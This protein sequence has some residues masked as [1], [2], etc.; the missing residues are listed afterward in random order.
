MASKSVENAVGHRTAARTT[1]SRREVLAKPDRQ[2][3]KCKTRELCQALYTEWAL[4]HLCHWQECLQ[5]SGLAKAVLNDNKDI[6]RSLVRAEA[7]EWSLVFSIV[8][9]RNQLDHVFSNFLRCL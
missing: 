9:F 8:F 7:Q 6:Q 2:K 3:M 4:C 5:T 1:V